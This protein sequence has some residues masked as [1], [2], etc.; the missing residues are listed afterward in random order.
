MK[1]SQFRKL[2]ELTHL[3]HRMAFVKLQECH[4]N[5]IACKNAIDAAEDHYEECQTAGRVKISEFIKGNYT[6][7]T[8][9][10][11]KLSA[12][13]ALT[14]QVNF[15]TESAKFALHEARIKLEEAEISLNNQQQ[16]YQKA[17]QKVEKIKFLS[18][19]VSAEEIETLNNIQETDRLDSELPKTLTSMAS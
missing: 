18:E 4:R 12:L 19:R 6:T 14:A 11:S 9:Y 7:D 8:N 2:E 17:T 15:E 5:V 16:V 1:P 3:R 10:P 13:R